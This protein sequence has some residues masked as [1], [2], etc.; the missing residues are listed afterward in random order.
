MTPSSSLIALAL[1]LV[2]TPAV[3]A[4][5]PIVQSLPVRSDA[6]RLAD[7]MRQLAVAPQDV[8][9]LASAGELS[10]KLDD[11]TAAA[12]FFARAD[13]VDPR[14]A[15]VKAG[16]GA[17]MVR[18]ERPGEALR[19]FSQAEGFGG[20]TSD[21]AAD[22]GLAYD[23]VGDQPHAQQQY[24]LALKAAPQ[25]DETV[26]RYALSLGIAG[27]RE[28]ALSE[29]EPLL[30]K[31]DRAAWRSRAFILAMNG[32]Q[33]GAEHIA[34]TMMPAGMA[35]G[36]LPFFQR[37]PT[38]TAVDRAFAVHFGEVRASADRLADAR[39]A[40]LA[41]PVAPEPVIQV[42]T[43]S[44][45]PVP[46]PQKKGR[47]RRSRRDRETAPVVL[48]VATAQALPP[49]PSYAA[50]PGV[51]AMAAPQSVVQRLP[52]GNVPAAQP[53]HAVPVV[54]RS[55]PPVP[56][57]AAPRPV[58]VAIVS[59][60]PVPTPRT[61]AYPSDIDPA[62]PLPTSVALAAPPRPVPV[63]VRHATHVTEDGILANI[64][65]GLSIPAAELDAAAPTHAPAAPAKMATSDDAERLAAQAAA[66]KIANDRK[67]A[68]EKR[69]ADRKAAAD[70]K[71]LAAKK[72][73]AEAKAIADKEAAEERKAA[74][75]N[76]E[77]IWVQVAGGAN[78]D[79]LPK[80]WKAAKA[81]A[82]DVFGA[83]NGWSTPLRATNR[84]LAGPFK[85]NDDAREFINDLRK[86]GVSSFSFTSEA[87][88]PVAKLPK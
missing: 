31:T 46:L 8:S 43:Q 20:R 84:V 62:A 76:P 65:A 9:A 5:Q 83:R 53:Y 30:R 29:L 13:K 78:E 1:A 80:A 66:D 25:D 36:L 42:A 86:K 70:K 35:Q 38:L 64:I 40:P 44:V 72:A 56:I 28:Q 19:Y 22:R 85:T 69:A 82:P 58:T 37:L 87:G 41:A 50:R 11:L 23:L 32:D 2:A 10:L 18:N 49:P 51:V 63:P 15:R 27:K 55:Q 39:M 77:R 12:G 81:K 26:R 14:N 67:F 73:A 24:R 17:L 61:A 57:A 68:S 71:A 79:D 45:Q 21:F 33:S 75:A 52:G 59:Q 3:F 47:D 16:E 48:P 60:P 54:L 4:A 7:T 34:T 6:D 74:R 88:Q